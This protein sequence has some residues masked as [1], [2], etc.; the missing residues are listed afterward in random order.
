MQYREVARATR[1]TVIT[2]D[3]A[4]VTYCIGLDNTEPLP[5]FMPVGRNEDGVFGSTVARLDRC[6]LFSHLPV[7]VIHDSPRPSDASDARM[8]WF[9]QTRLSDYVLA[10][11][12]LVGT[13]SAPADAAGRMSRL[14]ERLIDFASLKPDEVWEAISNGVVEQRVVALGRADAMWSRRAT[15][16]SYIKDELLA[17]RRWLF[18]CVSDRT[19]FIPAECRA[20]TDNDEPSVSYV[21]EYIRSFGA[22][23]AAWPALHTMACRE[24]FDGQM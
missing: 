12:Q 9:R 22:I 16:P 24:G 13:P 5:P 19:F 18:D 20:F 3:A 4:C 21:Q 23:L 10:A 17:C 6:A 15:Y 8:L 1:G 14:G 11:L 2:H 7:G